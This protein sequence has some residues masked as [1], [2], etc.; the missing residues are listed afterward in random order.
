MK[1]GMY[2]AYKD[3][4]KS[5][6]EAMK[7]FIMSGVAVP[8]VRAPPRLRPPGRNAP[9]HRA[10]PARSG[11][12]ATH[13]TLA[14]RHPSAPPRCPLQSRVPPQFGCEGSVYVA[15][16]F[17]VHNR[18]LRMVGGRTAVRAA[19]AAGAADYINPWEE[20]TELQYSVLGTG[21]RARW[22]LRRQQ[23]PLPG[24][25]P[26]RAEPCCAAP[27]AP[28]CGAPPLCRVQQRRR[29]APGIRHELP[30][31]WPHVS[32]RPARPGVT[33]RWTCASLGMQHCSGASMPWALLHRGAPP[34]SGPRRRRLTPLFN[35]NATYVKSL[36]DLGGACKSQFSTSTFNSVA[37]MKSNMQ[38]R[39]GGHSARGPC[40]EAGRG[41]G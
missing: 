33:L 1:L 29:H 40:S 30:G 18:R 14:T 2:K 37:D 24:G 9:A 31:P 16:Q 26:S 36:R 34:C 35:L 10:E 41:S 22:A 13:Q 3:I 11:C 38:A 21:A 27:D 7:K 8:R 17:G 4:P 20:G 12:A 15:H 28:R 23:S 19:G 5:G 6:I 39:C 25:R 32:R